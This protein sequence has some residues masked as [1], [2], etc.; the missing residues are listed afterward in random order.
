MACSVAF[1]G[2]VL[3]E[4]EGHLVGCSKTSAG[5]GLLAALAAADLP[6]HL[7]A[8]VG[9]HAAG[10]APPPPTDDPVAGAIGRLV[11]AAGAIVL[12]GERLQHDSNSQ[13]AA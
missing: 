7:S 9:G 10:S 11:A 12:G 1:D 13:C 4:L 6:P 3:A 8:S 5:P 2:Q